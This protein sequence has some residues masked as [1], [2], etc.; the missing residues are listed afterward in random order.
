MATYTT[1]VFTADQ[2]ISLDDLNALSNNPTAIVEGASGAPRLRSSPTDNPLRVATAGDVEVWRL[3]ETFENSCDNGS[4]AY[5][6]Q[7]LFRVNVS[8]VYRLKYVLDVDVVTSTVDSADL[9]SFVLRANS[10]G[11][12]STI[13]SSAGNVASGLK[14]FTAAAGDVVAVRSNLDLTA[15]TGSGSVT[16]TVTNI[17]IATA[18]GDLLSV[19]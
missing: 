7:H 17:L 18:Q 4:T 12:E 8:G 10:G 14:D 16:H 11:A 15:N 9:L 1:K 2:V 13:T 19:T 3:Y 6:Q 5:K